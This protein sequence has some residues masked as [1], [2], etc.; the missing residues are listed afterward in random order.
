MQKR[1]Q[2]ERGQAAVEFVLAFMFIIALTAV[3]F[4]ALH[5]E[6]D[7]FNRSMLARYEL[8]KEARHDQEETDG[9]NISKTIEGETLADLIGF[10]V[11]FQ[12]TDTSQRY[13]PKQ[14]Y[15][16]HG[17]KY[18]DPLGD[19]LHEDWQFA[20]LLLPDHY[21]PTSGY[22][23]QAFEVLSQITGALNVDI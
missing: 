7:V 3:L 14:I 2:Q 22:I 4:Q 23:G 5:F 11:P 20:A 16:R 21:E 13:G 6:L 18:L 15:T 10:E 9:H 19:V 1:Q 8:L 17:T 12:D